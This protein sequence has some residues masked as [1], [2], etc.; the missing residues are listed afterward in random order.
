MTVRGARFD[1]ALQRSGE[2]EIDASTC[3]CC[4]T[5]AALTDT[6]PLLVYRDRTKDEIRDI[7]RH[8]TCASASGMRPSPCTQTAGR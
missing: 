8:R 1:G 3:D 2:S 5:D 7:S 6:G 4:G